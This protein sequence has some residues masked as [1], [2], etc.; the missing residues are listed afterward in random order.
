MTDVVIAGIGQMPVGEHCEQTLRAMGVQRPAGCAQRQ[1]RAET[2]GTVYWQHARLGRLA[3]GEFG[4]ALHRLRPSGRHRILYRRSCRSLRRGALR[5]GY[6]A[7]LSG[8][9]DTVAVLGVE[10]WTDQTHMEAET[11]AATGAG[12]R[13]RSHAGAHRRP[14]RQG[15]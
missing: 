11:A 9:V 1:R 8:Y 5:M 6:L 13:L 4:R 10:K 3:P 15:C 12:W 2:A 7:I 14:V